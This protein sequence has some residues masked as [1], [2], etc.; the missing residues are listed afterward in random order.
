MSVP[1]ILHLRRLLSRGPYGASGI[2][3][4]R[5]DVYATW[6]TIC[7]E[8]SAGARFRRKIQIGYDSSFSFTKQL[9]TYNK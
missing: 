6:P 1:P 8:Y 4:Y 9:H 7:D 5:S 2:A 3:G